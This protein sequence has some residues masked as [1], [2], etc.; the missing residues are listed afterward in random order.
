MDES[1]GETGDEFFRQIEPIAAY[2][3]Y[4]SAVGNHEAYNN[5][6]HYVNRFTMPNSDHS[7]FYRFVLI[8]LS[9]KPSFRFSFEVGPVHFVVFSTEFYFYTQYGYHQI[10]NQYKWLISDLKKA[11]LNREKV[12]WII[13][14]AHRPMYCSDFDGDDCTRYESIVSDKLIITLS[15]FSS[16]PHRFAVNPWLRLGKVVLRIRSR[17]GALGS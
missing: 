7:L 2:I 10:E 11:N 12:P 15:I 5:F 3:P 16:D 1:N 8:T 17:S 6:T 4:M 13:T 9:V 14:M